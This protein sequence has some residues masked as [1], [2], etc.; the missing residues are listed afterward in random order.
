MINDQVIRRQVIVHG[1]VQGVCYRD[2]CR[3]R[4]AGLGVAGWVRN[5]PDGTVQA[6][7]EGPADAVRQLVA[8]ARQGPPAAAVDR[9]E[10]RDQPPEGLIGF[11]VLPTPR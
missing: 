4:A 10:V 5:L 2:S 7:F 6:V 1:T 8:W 11:A 9:V 3:S